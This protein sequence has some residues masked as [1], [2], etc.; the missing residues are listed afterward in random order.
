MKI[1]LIVAHYKNFGIGINNT[2][3]WNFKRDMKYFRELTSIQNKEFKNP[4]VIMGKNT[5]LSLPKKPLPKRMNYILSTT[6]ENEYSFTNI[7]DI[8]KDCQLNQI[9]VLWVIGG[10]KV[11]E[12]FLENDL[13]DYQIITVIHKKYNC[14]TFLKPYYLNNKWALISDIVFDEDNTNINFKV[15][16]RERKEDKINLY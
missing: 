15:F 10:S 2:L 4:A 6:I 12:S 7:D 5:W 1:N 9:D 11:Y 16:E 3:P 8:I 13:I 14:D